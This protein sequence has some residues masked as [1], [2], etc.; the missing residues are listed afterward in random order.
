MGR[1]QR[2][3]PKNMV[4]APHTGLCYQ[5]KVVWLPCPPHR[6]SPL[7]E[8]DPYLRAE[9]MS[10]RAQ[11]RI[12]QPIPHFRPRTEP[13]PSP[14][15]Q[16]PVITIQPPPP[17]TAAMPLPHLHHQSTVNKAPSSSKHH[18]VTSVLPINRPDI[19]STTPAVTLTFSKQCPP[20]R[21]INQPV[22][23]LDPNH[24]SEASS[25]PNHFSKMF[26]NCGQQAEDLS[27]LKHQAP[28]PSFAE[29]P[30][31]DV[32]RT[33]FI[34]VPQKVPNH[35][36]RV[37]TVAVNPSQQTL[38]KPRRRI[39]ATN[40]LLG[41]LKL[42]PMLHSAGS[43]STG[44][45]HCSRDTASKTSGLGYCAQPKRPSSSHP[46]LLCPWK[47]VS[48]LYCND[49][50][51]KSLGVPLSPPD[52]KTRVTNAFVPHQLQQA[53]DA[54]Y[55]LA[56][57]LFQM[58]KKPLE[59]IPVRTSQDQGARQLPLRLH[60]Q[61]KTLHVP[62]PQVIP[63]PHPEQHSRPVA[64]VSLQMEK[65]YSKTMPMRAGNQDTKPTRQAPWIIPPFLGMDGQKTIVF[66]PHYQAEDVTRSIA[67]PLKAM[68]P[69]VQ[70]QATTIIGVGQDLG[71]APSM[72]SY[73]QGINQL[74]TM[75]QATN[76]LNSDY[77][78]GKVANPNA[79]LIYQPN[80]ELWGTVTEGTN[81]QNMSPFVW[82]YGVTSPQNTASKATIPPRFDHWAT[83]P[84][85][86]EFQPEV[87]PDPNVQF[88]FQ[89][90]PKH[91]E[92]RQPAVGHQSTIIL[93]GQ[94]QRITANPRGVDDQKTTLPG[95]NCR[96][97]PR[98][99]QQPAMATPDPDAHVLLQLE[100]GHGEPMPS[101][102]E[103]WSPA[104]IDQAL[105]SV[106]SLGLDTQD[107]TLPISKHQATLL[108]SPTHQPEDILGYPKVQVSL[109]EELKQCEIIPEGIVH[110]TPN[111]TDLGQGVTLP[112]ST[113]NKKTTFLSPDHCTI[114]PPIPDHQ[115]ED[116][117]DHNGQDS[118]QLNSEHSETREPVTEQQS[119]NPIGKDHRAALPPLSKDKQETIICGSDHQ[120]MPHLGPD[121]QT[122]D[123][124][125]ATSDHD[126]VQPE[127]QHWQMVQPGTGQQ[128][129][130]P[131]GQDHI[132]ISLTL[133]PENPETILSGADHQ[134][135]L[136]L[137]RDFQTI[138]T[139]N[140]GTGVSC[141]TGQENK[142]RMPLGSKHEATTLLGYNLEATEPS[143]DSDPQ[144]KTL[145]A[146]G[147]H[148]SLLDNAD[149]N[150]DISGPITETLMQSEQGLWET[151]PWRIDEQ[152]TNTTA[153]DHCIM[154][155]LPGSDQQDT[156]PLNLDLPGAHISIQKEQETLPKETSHQ[157]AILSEVDIMLMP[158]LGFNSQDK[159]LPGPDNRATLSHSL[160]DQAKDVIDPI[161]LT[162]V[163][164][165]QEPGETMSLTIDQK[166][167]TV[168]GQDQEAA[169]LPPDLE[170]QNTAQYGPDCQATPTCSPHHRDENTAAFNAL[171]S[172]QPP[173][174]TYE[175]V[176]PET[177]QQ[178][179]ILMNLG[180]RTSPP[181]LKHPE[182]PAL[183][184][185][186]YQTIPP[187][188][189]SEA[190]SPPDLQNAP[191]SDPQCLAECLMSPNHQVTH[192]SSLDPQVT[193]F[194]S[195]TNQ[196][197]AKLDS[198]KPKGTTPTQLCN[199]ETALLSF[200]KHGTVL[201]SGPGMKNKCPRSDRSQAEV[202]PNFDLQVDMPLR[203]QCQ[204]QPTLNRKSSGL[205]Y[206]KPYAVEGQIVPDRIV[207]AIINSIPQE[208]IKN[209]IYKQILLRKM[210]KFSHRS[211]RYSSSYYPICLLCA[212]WIPNGC[213]HEGMKYPFEAQLL[214]LP[215]PMPG[216]E[217]LGVRFVLQVPQIT[218]C[219]YLDFP[220]SHYS[221]RRHPHGPPAF[222]SSSNPD[223]GLCRSSRPKWLH[224]I[225]GKAHQPGGKCHDSEFIGEMPLRNHS[226]REEETRDG[227]TFF[228]SLLERFQWKLKD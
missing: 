90:E 77:Q 37:T 131:T 50:L 9:Q 149:P 163:Q 184:G 14:R 215:T 136:S 227:R 51:P 129:T 132:E 156:C 109:Q 198:T 159:I 173:D 170:S 208:K 71:T 191:L 10:C 36:V 199:Q 123:I 96:V 107:S 153:C 119:R 110:Q 174:N 185:S 99:E 5:A 34:A 72:V 128:I 41:F 142:E 188:N 152:A 165:E 200:T 148:G 193:L 108:A 207:Q 29:V 127:E 222:S 6:V 95:P 1:K 68:P 189:P 145:L 59:T 12:I 125:D 78:I 57:G 144:H 56:H 25:S 196:G 85:Q 182:D 82:N 39:R 213:P 195:S 210:R 187:F 106:S 206:I 226:H 203:L 111:S 75:P 147:N 112:L 93:T 116:I 133:G 11:E 80:L 214:A 113:D 63:P 65:E 40:A 61:G 160:D 92:T 228:K 204:T 45:N 211:S 81:H 97:P 166:V 60:L 168:M 18:V 23:P 64:Q 181:L 138:D 141:K 212:S 44:P 17:R 27:H 103:I 151:M 101:K 137:S 146:P 171:V 219:S 13:V 4:Q 98:P 167:I 135:I 73:K 157:D 134:A 161:A 162:W 118:W 169:I 126:L 55:P 154:P 183:P 100:Q 172:L 121:Y 31:H 76:T 216:F 89:P 224:F 86:P 79:Q 33:M 32:H 3:F 190:F 62:D 223:L 43:I 104:V 178:A 94:N 2:I 120:D 49:H 15:F 220:Y 130:N 58:E 209:D 19:P 143:V 192:S 35:S 53:G 122:E 16:H 42:E 114:L 26:P 197:E 8:Q 201:P 20:L 217:E 30:P 115:P 38:P 24:H 158:T 225:L 202:R 150:V 66:V 155:P 88:S 74:G 164:T 70:P 218:A 83:P 140:P 84:P 186:D 46:N 102:I 28:F 205:N 124:Q 105:T 52:Q 221:L 91:H 22:I 69:R 177:G 48:L 117:L 54:T 87:I 21:P 194:P 179:E 47:T 175:T 176:P 180:F 67:Y 139:A 7:W